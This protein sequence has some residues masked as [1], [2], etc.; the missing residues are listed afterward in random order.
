MRLTIQIEDVKKIR[1]AEDN[2]QHKDRQASR[3]RVGR[4]IG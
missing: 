1:L 3:D 2:K 4:G